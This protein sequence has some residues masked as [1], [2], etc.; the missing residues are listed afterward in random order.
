MLSLCLSFALWV[1]TVRDSPAIL[2]ANVKCKEKN[3]GFRTGS[4]YQAIHADST[5][6]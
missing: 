1:S 3:E 5:A 4:Y 2:A 6:E